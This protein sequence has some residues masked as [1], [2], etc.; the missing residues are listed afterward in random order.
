MTVLR[1]CAF[2]GVAA[3]AVATLSASPAKAFYGGFRGYGF[4]YGGFYP[5]FGAGLALGG[6]YGGFYPRPYP[7]YAPVYVAPPPVVYVPRPVYLLPPP[8]LEYLGPPP[9]PR[10]I[11]HHV[12]VRHTTPQCRCVPALPST[13]PAPLRDIPSPGP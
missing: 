3:L 5:G 7:Y 13:V 2:I 6:L 8:P 4:G 11:V 12:T 10:R 9:R 1:R